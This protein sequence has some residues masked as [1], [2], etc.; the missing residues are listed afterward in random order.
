MFQY[1]MTE[2]VFHSSC[3]EETH[4]KSYGIECVEINAGNERSVGSI[5]DISTKRN[6][7]ETLTEKMNRQRLSPLHFHDVVEDEII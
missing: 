4:Y 2:T 1:R 3:V 7:V 6:F 5:L